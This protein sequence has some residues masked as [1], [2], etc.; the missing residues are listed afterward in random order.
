MRSIGVIVILLVFFSCRKDSALPADSNLGST[1]Y[2]VVI[3]A[4][5]PSPVYNFESNALSYDKVMLGRYLFYESMLSLDSSI[6]C[7]SC[8]QQ[9]FA[10]SNGPGNAFSHG[11]NNQT[12]IRNAIALFNLNWHPKLMWDGGVSNIENQPIAPI[13]NALEFNLPL[14]QVIKRLTA[15]SKYKALFAKAYGDSSVN[16]QRMLKAMAQFMGVLVSYNSKY[17]QVKRGENVFNGSEEAGYTIFK[18]KCNACHTEPLFS[19]YSFRNK[20]LA[21]GQDSGRYRITQIQSDLYKFKVPSLRN[22]GFTAPYMHDGRFNSLD[23]VLDFYVSGMVN[24]DPYLASEHS[25]S[26]DEKKDLLN[27]LSALND[28]IFVKDKRF[29]EIH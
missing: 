18:N 22:L 23:A 10:F 8:H 15:S 13:Q 4:G 12:G 26:A 11:V 27:F 5:W 17:D 1:G 3:P 6:S 25:L 28:S 16:S 2:A 20:G 14:V 21:P 19:D 29:S 7:G 9:A 24:P